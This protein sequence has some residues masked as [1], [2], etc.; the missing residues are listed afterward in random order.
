MMSSTAR[1][2]QTA[3]TDVLDRADP[4]WSRLRQLIEEKSLKRGD[5]IL[6]SKRTSKFLFQLRQTTMLPEGQALLGEVVVEFMQKR[7]LKCVGGLELGAVPLVAAVAHASHL[8]GY[9]VDAFFVRKTAKE[10]GAKERIDGHVMAEAEVLLVDDVST[11]GKSMIGA[12]DGVKEHSPSSFVR[13]A[14]VVVDRQEGATEFLASQ[15]I[16]LF[17]IFAKSDFAI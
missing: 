6:S 9:P 4:R 1:P 2:V 7:G 3:E 16:K 14:L 13:Q 10:H 15:G 8:K 11:S 17:S 5:F 12:V